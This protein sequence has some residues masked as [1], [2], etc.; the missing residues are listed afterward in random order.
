MSK[1]RLEAFGNGVF[2]VI[3]AIMVLNMNMPRGTDLHALKSV[4]PVFL[5]YVLSYIYVGIYWN[6]HHH[7]LH[8][9]EHATGAFR[10]RLDGRK[11]LRTAPCSVIR[12]DAALCG[13]R[14]FHSHQEFDC[15]S[16]EELGSGKV[17]WERL[18][19]NGQCA[20]FC[21]RDPFGLR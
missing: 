19:R 10:N 21:A 11:S 5:C 3:I 18:D 16:W 1:G 6:N 9:S 12:N 8:A 2:A 4:L 7:L 15:T 20:G 17:Y 13:Y 14:I